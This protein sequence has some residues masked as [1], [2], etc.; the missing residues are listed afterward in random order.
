M[1]LD[2]NIRHED[3]VFRGKI[4]VGHL[5]ARQIESR[6]VLRDSRIRPGG[7]SG[8]LVEERYVVNSD[9]LVFV[10]ISSI[11]RLIGDSNS[12]LF[13]PNPY[14]RNNIPILGEI[15]VVGGEW[16]TKSISISRIQYGVVGIS[17][18]VNGKKQLF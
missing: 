1:S 4:V 10:G 9:T 14:W 7:K 12:N 17:L 11:P 13:S 3:D 5:P 18:P 6:P 2:N 8:K 15:I 16:T